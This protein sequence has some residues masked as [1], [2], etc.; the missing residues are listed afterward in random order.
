MK[1]CLFLLLLKLCGT[2]LVFSQVTLQEFIIEKDDN[3]QVFYKGKGCTPDVGV[4]VFYTTISDLKFSMPDTPSRLKN[5]PTFDKANN[6]Y[7]LCVQPTD[8]KIGGIMQYSVAITGTGYKPM[9]AYM[10]SDINAGRAQHFKIK[11][12]EDWKSAFE[13]LKKEIDKLKGESSKTVSLQEQKP[14]VPITSAVP[15]YSAMS[16]YQEGKSNSNASNFSEAIR[17][18]RNALDINPNMSDAWYNLGI[19]YE[20]KKGKSEAMEC[21]QKAAQLG[22]KDAQ[23]LLTLQKGESSSVASPHEQKPVVPVY[24][25]M[26][27]YQEGKL[28]SD[29]GNYSEAIRCYRNAL[30]INPNMSDAWYNLG[31]AYER[32]K[33]KFEAMECYQKAAR[34]GNKDAQELLA[35]TD[36]SNINIETPKNAKTDLE[37][38]RLSISAEKQFFLTPP[39]YNITIDGKLKFKMKGGEEKVLP[40]AQGNHNVEIKMSFRKTVFTI[41]IKKDANILLCMNRTTGKIDVTV[42]FAEYFIL[43]HK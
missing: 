27:W 9:P 7:V 20:R 40:V 6:C 15:A 8:T 13:N 42:G 38:F 3:P 39:T 22:N 19:A 2:A 31:I 10:V 24:S 37:E 12:E 17:C 18:Y 41:Q 21:Y 34:L 43:Q 11:I 32:E 5:T 29:A 16:W 28:N 25:A 14:V 23:R 33:K 35:L 4:I 1:H 30:E 26:S 36:N